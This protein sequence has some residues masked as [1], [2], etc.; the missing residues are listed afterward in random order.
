MIVLLDTLIFWIRLRTLNVCGM[1]VLVS[2]N[3][4]I[5]H[6]VQ[7]GIFNVLVV[8]KADRLI[9]E[10]RL[11]PA[12]AYECPATFLSQYCF[13]LIF[14]RYSVETSGVIAGNLCL[15]SGIDNSIT[16]TATVVD[17]AFTPPDGPGKGDNLCIFK[18][19]SHL[20]NYP[21][22]GIKVEESGE[23]VIIGAGEICLDC[24]LFDLREISS[25][26]E[27]EFSDPVVKFC[28]TVVDTQSSN[29][30]LKLETKSKNKLAMIAEP[31]EKGQHLMNNYQ[32]DLLASRSIWAFGSEIN[33]GGTKILVND[34]L[35]TKVD[36]R[37][38][39]VDCSNCPF[40]CHY[41][42]RCHVITTLALPF[43]ATSSPNA[44]VLHWLRL[45][46]PNLAGFRS[47]QS[48]CQA[49]D[50]LLMP[51]EAHILSTSKEEDQFYDNDADMDDLDDGATLGGSD[52]SDTSDEEGD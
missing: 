16:K 23:H 12:N 21:L 6:L 44:I 22:V 51:N 17:S 15:I 9:L 47:A 36:K 7:E 40:I 4:I 19:I 50:S 41:L 18:P 37:Y 13:I 52:L 43:R 24:C 30:L 14:L 46:P 29:A 39:Q 1:Q 45:I 11:P 42:Y 32:W 5:R 25:K 48:S 20:T 2:T 31:L 34:T 26:I 10:L 8:N 27:D 38:H 28:E 49:S 3:K 33:G 35:P